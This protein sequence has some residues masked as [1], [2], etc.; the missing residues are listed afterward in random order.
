MLE[1][2][3]PA[4]TLCLGAGVCIAL[5]AA[6]PLAAT[7]ASSSARAQPE[8]A[9]A[10]L[11]VSER[12]AR[13]V[14]VT[15]D[16][17]ER[18]AQYAAEELAWHVARATEAELPIVAEAEQESHDASLPRIYVGSTQAALDHGIDHTALPPEHVV[19]RHVGDDLFIAGK[20]GPGSA[21]STSNIHSGTLWG[22]YEVLERAL[23]ARWLWPGEHGVVVRESASLAVPRFDQR[24][25][26]HFVSRLLRTYVPWR[27]D[28]TPVIYHFTRAGQDTGLAYASE[29]ALHQYLWDQQVFLRRHRMGTSQ[30]PNYSA[31]H[32]FHDWWEKYGES[33]PEW[34]QLL[35]VA[36]GE[37]ADKPVQER[38][39]LAYGRPQESMNTRRGP[40]NPDRPALVSMC[41]SN[42]E[43]HQ[44]IIEQWKL[45][46]ENHPDKD[47]P[48]DIGE[49]DLWALCICDECVKLDASQK[50]AAEIAALP[51]SVPG[52][53]RPFDA[54]RRYAWFYREI[55]KLA[56]EV[57]PDAKVLGYVY[58]NYFVAPEDI[59]L[60]P[61]VILTFVPWGGF[62][63]PRDPREQAWL[64]D[65][66]R[67]WRETGATLFY[68]PNFV[69]AG[70]SMPHNYASQMI[71]LFDTF[72][73]H[74]AIG[75]DFDA[76]VGQWS[77]RGATMY[78][79]LRKHT[80]PE[81]SAGQLLQEY[82]NAFGPAA[83]HI[84]AYFDYW[85]AH[86]TVSRAIDP[87]AMSRNRSNHLL[88]YARSI[89]ALY[90]EEDLDKAQQIL[91]RAKEA[92]ASAETGT[93]VRPGMEDVGEQSFND[94][95][96]KEAGDLE[97]FKQRVQYIQHGLTHARKV[98]AVSAAFAD[99]NATQ[100]DREAA[101]R[102]L[103]R[104]RQETEHLHIANYTASAADEQRSF[105]DRY[106]FDVKP[107]LE[108]Q[109]ADT[110][111]E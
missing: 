101:F 30:Q 66:W 1:T 80:H 51:G 62:Y 19:L 73:H 110:P 76:R 72:I 24:V 90:P 26:P 70:G 77:V 10:V 78:A 55:H 75:T 60:H 36:E 61:N 65:Q 14:I 2:P 58:L 53:H 46:R 89:H 79:L 29:D 39:R 37:F 31:G 71:D 44:Q 27:D 38:A 6:G 11:W 82:Y 35:P 4:M 111:M 33:H 5:L 34:F 99:D 42:R 108:E 15:P 21:L 93:T 20:D 103:A 18:I 69:F 41:V 64:E 63:Y 57:D 95:A 109:P 91:D 16:E 106:D 3:L 22:V 88:T 67:Q 87:G 105:S 23:E 7:G 83:Y 45:E 81:R 59:E 50:S 54:G 100:T 74:G 92:L 86:T 85:E 40:D 102:D 28:D 43:L 13:A 52:L 94:Q 32:S 17:P 12:E 84:K 98:R 9:E 8:A 47:I 56:T 68:R 49:N 48:I 25:E 97:T 104:F 107:D 96:A